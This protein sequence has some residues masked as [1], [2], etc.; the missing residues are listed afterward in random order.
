[1]DASPPI[2]ENA[3]PMPMALDPTPEP[4][5]AAAELPT[6]DCVIATENKS[7]VINITFFI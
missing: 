7:I 6:L 2:A 5:N 1:M 4:R 3:P